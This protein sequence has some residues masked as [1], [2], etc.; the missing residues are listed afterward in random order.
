MKA[1]VLLVIRGS[2]Q[3]S[4]NRHTALRALSDSQDL[5]Y[6]PQAFSQR[7]KGRADRPAAKRR[8]FQHMESTQFSQK[9]GVRFTA[10]VKHRR[11]LAKEEP[12][13]FP[14]L[15]HRTGLLQLLLPVREA[16]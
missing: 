6:A 8:G 9:L 1:R 3:S 14:G 15:K 12:P 7:L 13:S 4:E 16:A 5:R 2:L 10:S 11:S